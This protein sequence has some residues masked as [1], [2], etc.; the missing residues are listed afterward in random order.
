VT[1]ALHALLAFGASPVVQLVMFCLSILGIVLAIRSLQSAR[2]RR[3]MCYARRSQAL[4]GGLDA[5]SSSLEVRY[6]GAAIPRVTYTTLALWNAGDTSI[7]ASDIP[8]SD[9]IVLK[10]TGDCAMLEARIA[11]FRNPSSDC[12]LVP[13]SESSHRVDFEYLDPGDGPVIRCLHTGSSSK[14]LSLEGAVIG[15]GRVRLGSPDTLRQ[16]IENRIFVPVTT[17]ALTLFVFMPLVGGGA[18]I[19]RILGTCV[20]AGL[21]VAFLVIWTRILREQALAVPAELT[22]FWA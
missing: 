3:L 4:V 2:R 12:R 1:G 18:L 14:S 22:S 5:F 11:Q 10:S 9:P 15:G 8:A 21:L 17:I 7:R 20:G 6:N 19:L 13:L 16:R